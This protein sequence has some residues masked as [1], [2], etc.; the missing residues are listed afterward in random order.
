MEKTERVN[1]EIKFHFNQVLEAYGDRTVF[2]GLYGSQNYDLDTENSDVDTK[3]IVLPTIHELMHYKKVSHTFIVRENEEGQCDVKHIQL[4]FE[5]FMKQNI[6]F[7]ELLYTPYYVV[8]DNFRDL[9][10]QVVSGRDLIAGC[11]IKKMIHAAAGM[12]KQKYA[13]MEKR[14]E[15]KIPLIEK[16]GYDPKQLA[17]LLRLEYFCEYYLEDSN[18]ERAIHPKWVPRDTILSVKVTP[19]SLAVA[20]KMANDSITHLQ[21]CVDRVASLPSKTNEEEVIKTFL[22][23]I[24]EIAV[25]R[26]LRGG[27]DNDGYDV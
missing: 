9:W 25:T 7:L 5:N 17:S 21:N 11:N 2:C 26:Y 12:G 6:N 27:K 22:D 8:A 24:A 16:Y 3:A 13:A 4:M 14:F 1:S 10:K 18:F 19:P 20:R 23:K 15:S